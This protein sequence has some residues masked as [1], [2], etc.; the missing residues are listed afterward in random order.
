M[1][2][3]SFNSIENKQARKK[4]RKDYYKLRR[5]QKKNRELVKNKER[6]ERN[7]KYKCLKQLEQMI[8]SD[9]SLTQTLKNILHG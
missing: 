2:T 7:K 3:R 9:P 1:R 5:N 8:T 6:N 4:A